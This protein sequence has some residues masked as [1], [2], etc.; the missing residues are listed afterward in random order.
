LPVLLPVQPADSH[1][2]KTAA[3]KGETEMPRIS[4]A[5]FDMRDLAQDF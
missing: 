5:L 3:A 2:R 1:S 4:F